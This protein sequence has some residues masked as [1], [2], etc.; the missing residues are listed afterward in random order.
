MLHLILL[1]LI[2][3]TGH[4]YAEKIVLG[5]TVIGVGQKI[6]SENGRYFIVVQEDG[7]FVMYRNDMAVRFATYKYGSGNFAWMQNDGNFVHYTST[8]QPLWHTHTF[9]NPGA[10]LAVQNDGNLV[11]YSSIGQGLWSIGAEPSPAD[12]RYAGDVV[13]RDMVYEWAASLGHLG[14]WD[15]S[16]VMEVGPGGS[17]AIKRTYLNDFKTASTNGYWGSVA[18]KFPVYDVYDCYETDCTNWRWL[19]PYGASEK[20]LPRQAIAR[21]AYQSFL[22]GANYTALADYSDPFPRDGL[23]PAQRGWYRCDS[24]VV[25]MYQRTVNTLNNYFYAPIDNTWRSKM[26]QL[27][28]SERY[29]KNIFEKLRTFQ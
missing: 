21:A 18:P 16:R 24:F 20:V 14:I 6:Y 9:N 17:N 25:A 19:K 1:G 11:V 26:N 5:N 13:G 12:P 28:D 22:L 8:T 23:W 29:P 27:Y 7:N 2:F 4:A 10:F 15:G 3:C